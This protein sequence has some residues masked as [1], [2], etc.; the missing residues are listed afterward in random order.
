[1][2]YVPLLLSAAALLLAVANAAYS[3]RRDAQGDLSGKLKDLDGKLDDSIRRL[4]ILET[5]ISVFWKGVSF[6]SAAALHSPHT[7]ALDRL[8]EKF[9]ADAFENETELQELKT[10]LQPIAA[11]DPLPFRRKLASDILTLIHV[12]YEIGGLTIPVAKL[13]DDRRSGLEQVAAVRVHTHTVIDEDKIITQAEER[14]E[15]DNS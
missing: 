8:L 2:N 12:R 11:N 10:L 7:P 3:R 9:Q 13:M 1:M 6:S 4:V 5:Q 14:R 15:C